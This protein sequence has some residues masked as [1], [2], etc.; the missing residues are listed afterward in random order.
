MHNSL[1]MLPSSLIAFSQHKEAGIILQSSVNVPHTARSGLTQEFA[2]DTHVV[3]AVINNY[4]TKIM[5][6]SNVDCAHTM[7]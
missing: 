7:T 1:V 4:N 3:D 6:I 2:R 5:Q